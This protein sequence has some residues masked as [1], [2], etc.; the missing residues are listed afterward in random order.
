M[1]YLILPILFILMSCDEINTKKNLPNI[2]SFKQYVNK[3]K[4][5]ESKEFKR[6]QKSESLE[7]YINKVNKQKPV[8]NFYIKN[9]N[10]FTKTIRKRVFN[11]GEF[12]ITKRIKCPM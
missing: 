12:V 1:K 9:G 5:T 10:C 8:V 2:K 6:F 3:L 7:S 11:L 4:K